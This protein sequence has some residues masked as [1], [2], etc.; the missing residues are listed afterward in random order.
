MPVK[1][2]TVLSNEPPWITSSLK[3]LIKSRQNDLKN[4]NAVEFNWLRNLVN[5]VRKHCRAKYYE[6]KVQRL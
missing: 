5:Q 4:G 1:S 3:N 6:A 2:K